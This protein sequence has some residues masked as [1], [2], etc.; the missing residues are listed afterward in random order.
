MGT[1]IKNYHFE[2]VIL[3][4]VFIFTFIA[5]SFSQ[6]FVEQNGQLSVKGTR[7]VNK[8]G[9]TVQLKGMSFFWSQ[10]I[11]KYYTYNT[12]KWLRDDWKCNVVRA[13]I[14]VNGNIDGYLVSPKIEKQ[15]AFTIIDAAIDLGIYVIVDWHDHNAQNHTVEAQKFFVELAKKY[16][17]TPNI[18]YE[19]FNEPLAVSWK[20]VIKPYHEAVIDSIRAYDSDNIIMCG[21]KTWSQDVDEAS[22]N[23]IKDTNIVYTL[24]Y[25]AST[26]KQSL[27]NK[28]AIAIKNG[29][30][31][32]V[33]EYGTCE[34]S[35][36]GFMDTTETKTWWRF[37]DANKIGYC[38]WS[39]SDKTETA[40]ALK[41]GASTEGGWD[42]SMLSA[43]GIFVR[44]NLLGLTHFQTVSSVEN[45][46]NNLLQM[47][48]NP[49]QDVLYVSL[50]NLNSTK[51]EVLVFDY[52]G[53]QI[54][55]NTVSTT[56]F[57]LSTKSL[58]PGVYIL[59]LIDGGIIINQR[60]L[61]Y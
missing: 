57:T 26:H 30:A 14:G 53:R 35:G 47:F 45:T 17:N 34:S 27:R 1:T 6:T 50:N 56:K 31:L 18:I 21:S 42:T 10:W 61:K 41:P 55:R 29:A 22:G 23:M 33:S 38:N 4:L 11:G 24:H 43:S 58:V 59:K 36:S 37:L 16:G 54:I 15:K 9:D 28:A 5:N 8:D 7:I 60:F 2:R 48:P 19:T 25:Y 39:I 40:S 12:I 20:D 44:E 52:S 13:A 51:A 3:S 46:N 49:T 32:F